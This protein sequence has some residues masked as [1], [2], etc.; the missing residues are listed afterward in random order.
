MEEETYHVF[1]RGAHKQPIFLDEFD[2]QRFQVLLYIA[3]CIGPIDAGKILQKYRGP[4]FA[5][6]FGLE[7]SGDELVN[8][9]AY[10]L[11][12]NH[13]HLVLKQKGENG[14]SMFM[15]KL[16]TGYS[17]YFNLKHDHSGTLFQGRFKSSHVNGDPCFEW[18]FAYVHL[19]PISIVEPQWR[20]HGA[21]D[22]RRA[23]EFLASYRYS[24]YFDYYAAERPERTILAYEE[25][26]DFIDK[27]ADLIE[28]IKESKKGIPLHE[29]FESGEK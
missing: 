8:V 3:N 9:F 17:M 2:H 14:I 13:F 28:L 5:D 24:S 18:L 16:C 22:V 19:N 10:S 25:A 26:V 21:K 29:T 15:R 6:L 11:L 7:R 12:P 4:S 27:N 20:E 1:N 23:L